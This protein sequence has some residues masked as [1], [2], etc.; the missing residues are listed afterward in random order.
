M[1]EFDERAS[2]AETKRVR[3][4]R[5]AASFERC[6]DVVA[7]VVL[8][9]LERLKDTHPRGHRREIRFEFL[10]IERHL[11]GAVVKTDPGDG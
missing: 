6:R 3:L 10:P 4:T 11:T 5:G 2:D 1:P 9:D 7:P 8:G